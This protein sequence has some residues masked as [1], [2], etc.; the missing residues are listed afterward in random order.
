MAG[1]ALLVFLC[2]TGTR[3]DYPADQIPDLLIINRDTLQLKTFPLE[4]LGFEIRPF[5]YG[6]YSFP[7][8]HCLRGYQAIWEVLDHKLFLRRINK[9]ND[10]QAQLDLEAYFKANQYT[11]VVQNGLILADWFTM[12]LNAYPKKIRKC[13]YLFKTYKVRRDKPVMR[14]EKG[15]LRFNRYH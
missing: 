4:E 6:A 14:F 5:Q 1:L 3:L 7:D 9:I 12:S 13:V 15:I 10:P 11:P 2:C 8:L